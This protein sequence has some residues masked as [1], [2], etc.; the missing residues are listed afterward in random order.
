MV[1]FV[2]IDGSVGGRGGRARG[3]LSRCTCA[4]GVKFGFQAECE[5]TRGATCVGVEG[6]TRARVGRPNVRGDLHAH[7]ALFVILLVP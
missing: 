6:G 3:H 5:C 1:A 2:G 4:R 7:L